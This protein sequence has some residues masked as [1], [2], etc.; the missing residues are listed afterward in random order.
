VILRE[1]GAL[2]DLFDG[3]G[4]ERIFIDVDAPS[5]QLAFDLLQFDDVGCKI[6]ALIPFE[7]DL[8]SHLGFIGGREFYFDS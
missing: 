7:V 6:L 5:S 1:D 3:R 8:V 4:N 2:V